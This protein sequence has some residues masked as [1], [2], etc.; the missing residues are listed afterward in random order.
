MKLYVTSGCSFSENKPGTPGT[1][2]T[3]LSN[4]INE[5]QIG[6]AYNFGMGGAGV[7]WAYRT[8][9]YGV[10]DLLN[11][12]IDNKDIKVVVNWPFRTTWD[13]P[14]QLTGQELNNIKKNTLLLKESRSDQSYGIKRWNFDK[15][16]ILD[17]YTNKEDFL[18]HLVSY[19]KQNWF[20]CIDLLEKLRNLLKIESES[21]N[22][23]N[24]ESSLIVDLNYYETILNL[25]FFLNNYNIDYVFFSILNIKRY[26]P[27]WTPEI[28]WDKKSKF[29]KSLGCDC[30]VCMGIE[31]KPR[32]NRWLGQYEYCIAPNYIEQPLI[33]EKLPH[34]KLF[35]D[36]IDWDKWWFYK[37]DK[38]DFGGCFEYIIENCKFFFYKSE[39]QK[40]VPGGQH[41]N[42]HAWEKFFNNCLLPFMVER[43]LI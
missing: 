6:K 41:P 7:D 39:Q 19:D 43:E 29:L 20:T 36:Q 31:N 24:L 23:R 16:D 34:V 25:Q 4:Y 12:G 32:P 9:Q 14:I 40:I 21:I 18:S 1:W 22:D 17:G 8:I 42:R 33:T 35:Y 10:M 3:Q 11:G 5:H 26:H 2:T 13:I 37:S 15:F 28:I 30:E 38:T 27:E